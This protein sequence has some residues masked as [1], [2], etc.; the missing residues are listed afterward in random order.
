ML[1]AQ[2]DEIIFEVGEDE[3]SNLGF[4]EQVHRI[5]RTYHDHLVYR[6]RPSEIDTIFSGVQDERI[7]DVFWEMWQNIP[8]MDRDVLRAMRIK[9]VEGSLPPGT[10]GIC[11]IDIAG[12]EYGNLWP[13]PIITVD[14]SQA[15]DDEHMLQT[16]CH[17]FAHAVYRH[18]EIEF[19]INSLKISEG[20][21]SLLDDLLEVHAIIVGRAWPWRAQKWRRPTAADAEE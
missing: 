13:S 11:S 9:V 14:P 15:R 1:K 8:P 3:W 5:I 10:L 12:D 2:Y 4:D 17:E 16:L 20:H 6:P 7:R 21:K 19:D 18:V